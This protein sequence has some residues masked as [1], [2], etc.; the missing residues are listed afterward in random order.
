MAKLSDVQAKV[1]KSKKWG[2]LAAML[3][4]T[5]LPSPTVGVTHQGVCLVNPALALDLGT[6]VL[7]SRVRGEFKQAQELRQGVKQFK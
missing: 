3:G 4:E 7:V 2:F 1:R 5:A 6:D